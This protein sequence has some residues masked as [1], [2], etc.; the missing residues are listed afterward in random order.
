MGDFPCGKTHNRSLKED[1]M[2]KVTVDKEQKLVEATL[3][4]F[5]KVEDAVRASNEVKATM[6]LFGPAQAALLIDLLGFAP[7]SNDVL[8]VLRGMGRDVISFFRK[9][10]LVQEIPIEVGGRKII[11]A[12]PGVKV[13][14][15]MT[16]DEAIKYLLEP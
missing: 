7:M 1:R 3:T 15:Y 8:P 9:T 12:P 6:K 11:E 2:V 5:V 10:A 14:R 13:P 4:G 16:R